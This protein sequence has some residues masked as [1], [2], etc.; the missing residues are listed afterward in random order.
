MKCVVYMK[1]TGQQKMNSRGTNNFR[2]G[3]RA[4]KPGG[5]F[6]GFHSEGQ[7]AIPSARN[8]TG[9]LG[10]LIPQGTFKGR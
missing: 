3:K 9:E 1:G 7:I 2:D 4:N 8:D 10:G 6:A 5:E